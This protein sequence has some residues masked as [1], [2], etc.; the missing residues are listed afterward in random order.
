MLAILRC[1]RIIS[2]HPG[3]KKHGRT[4]SAASTTSESWSEARSRAQTAFPGN[5]VK[6]SFGDLDTTDGLQDYECGQGFT[7]AGP[8]QLLMPKQKDTT[9][10]GDVNVVL[11]VQ[12]LSPIF[13]PVVHGWA[14]QVISATSELCFT[15]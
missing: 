5:R 12:L 8:A 3:D 2:S 1:M 4:A 7:L 15:F 10:F 9:K 6:D 14:V 11:V 13:H